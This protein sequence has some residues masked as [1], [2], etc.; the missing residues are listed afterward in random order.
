[1]PPL[2]CLTAE[3]K[4]ILAYKLTPDSFESLRAEQRA[5]HNLHFDCC[6]ATVGL[7]VSRNGLQHFYH[8]GGR[9]LCPY[10]AE[11]EAHLSL[12]KAVADAAAEANWAAECEK[13]SGPCDEPWR[14]DVFAERGAAKI[15]VEV[16]LANL[17]WD[18]IAQR[19]ARYRAAG[20]RGLWLLGQQNYH[21]SQEV[22]AFQV[23]LDGDGI[24]QVRVSPPNDHWNVTERPYQ[25]HWTPLEVFIK[26]ALTKNLVWSP[27]S[28]LNR[29]DV[30]IRTG[31]ALRCNCGAKVLRPSSLAVALPFPGHRTLLWTVLSRSPQ[32]P[33]PGPRWLNE[34]VAIINN[35]YP[36]KSG[37]LL[38]TRHLRGRAYHYYQCP[39]CGAE[40]DDVT[41]RHGETAITRRDLPF[42]GLLSV[43]LAGSPEHHF[44]F[45]WWLRTAR[46]NQPEHPQMALDL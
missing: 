2:K 14:A 44:V 37:A 25:G 39:V 10:E 3:N 23:R 28:D 24:W 12:K 21:V 42:R 32:Q 4:V 45:Q 31:D 29:V 34:L 40:K 11:S 6:E 9:G 19:Q 36:E 26:A 27:V 5:T 35:G 13:S 43:P 17:P 16:Q 7:R 30:I 15:A 20:V 18:R 1:M 41:N 8:L 33:N 46:P 38:A 22:P